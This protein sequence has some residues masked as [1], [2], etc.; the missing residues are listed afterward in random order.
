[1]SSATRASEYVTDTMAL[2]LRLEGRRMGPMARSAFESAESGAA[3]VHVP[4]MVLAELLYL[5]E[6]QRIQAAIGS[7]VAYLGAHPAVREYPL[8]LAVIQAAA[9]ITD[10]PELHDRL[11]AATA[12]H[13]KLELVTNDPVIRSL[14]FLTTVW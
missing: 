10:I 8:D 3:I 13:L 1:M 6:R 5:S 12:R 11:I 7:V 4:A 14:A 2:V 9:Q